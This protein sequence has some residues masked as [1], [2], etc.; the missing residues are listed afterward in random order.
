MR[1]KTS[2]IK[3]KKDRQNEIRTN[4]LK[5]SKFESQVQVVLKQ[6]DSLKEQL[7]EVR[8]ELKKTKDEYTH[9]Q[10]EFIQHQ[11]RCDAY[12]KELLAKIIKSIN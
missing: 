2:S 1:W 11:Q 10:K 6:R 9:L 4:H 5:V 8:D 7:E 3:A 12:R